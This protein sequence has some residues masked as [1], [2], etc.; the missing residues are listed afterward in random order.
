MLNHLLAAATVRRYGH[1]WLVSET[2]VAPA[3]ASGPEPG[4][5]RMEGA[6]FVRMAKTRGNKLT[7]SMLVRNEADRYLSQVLAHAARYI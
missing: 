4:R 6:P 3:E 1:T 7:L 5:P 2:Q